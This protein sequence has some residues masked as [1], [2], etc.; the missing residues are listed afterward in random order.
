[1]VA[2]LQWG[3]CLGQAAVVALNLDLAKDGHT[4]PRQLLWGK[5][6]LV[7]IHEMIGA[8]ER[9]HSRVSPDLDSDASPHCPYLEPGP[10]FGKRVGPVFVH[11]MHGDQEL[12][13]DGI[14]VV[15]IADLR[16]VELIPVMG[17][18]RL[19]GVPLV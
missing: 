8:S 7:E 11:E 2:K 17:A 16:Q 12:R 14:T 13:I 9:V 5:P 3:Q 18:V 19:N 6:S 4:V 15:D 10:V 1:D